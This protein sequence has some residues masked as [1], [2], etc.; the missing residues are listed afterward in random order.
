MASFTAGLGVQCNF[1]H[2]PDR[3]S[4]ENPHKGVARKMMVMLNE[5]NA[6][7]PAGDARV[8]CYT[9]HRGEN[10]PKTAPPAATL[11]Q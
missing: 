6:K 11:S 4:D 2:A 9:C 7:F 1:C 10:V 8:T 5:V 3:S